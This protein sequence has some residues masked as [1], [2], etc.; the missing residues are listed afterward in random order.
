MAEGSRSRD[1]RRSTE[2]ELSPSPG[3]VIDEIARISG[4]ERRKLDLSA[5]DAERLAL[6]QE[7]EDLTI[8]LVGLTRLQT[9]L[10][11]SGSQIAG[12]TAPELRPP[13]VILEEWTEAER[14]LRDVRTWMDSAT[15]AAD[16]LREEHS[17]SVLHYG[18]RS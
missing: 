4:L 1:I 8:R 9:R 15:D 14:L 2:T 5:G 11:G 12:S 16:R 13:A 18:A 17:R 10:I 7:I 6:A 3:I